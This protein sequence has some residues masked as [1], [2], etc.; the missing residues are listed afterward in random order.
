MNSHSIGRAVSIITRTGHDLTLNDL[1]ST[2]G[3]ATV[4]SQSLDSDLAEAFSSLSTG[5]EVAIKYGSSLISQL[6]REHVGA[7]TLAAAASPSS[8]T[9]QL[10]IFVSGL[11]IAPVMQ[12]LQDMTKAIPTV[13]GQPSPTVKLHWDNDRILMPLLQSSEFTEL[14]DVLGSTVTQQLCRPASATS[15]SSSL[16][17][18]R[19]NSNQLAIIA[20]SDDFVSNIRGSL[21]ASG[22][23]PGHILCVTVPNYS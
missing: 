19:F 16:V 8:A 2:A 18:P 7:T 15:T 11:G 4:A 9:S 10:N 13:A 5:D 20:G 23:P 1:S 6:S 22:Y 14:C 17:I 21:Q 12:M 3:H